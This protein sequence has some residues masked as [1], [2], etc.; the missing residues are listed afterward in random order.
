[1]QQD[2]DEI[3]EELRVLYVALTRAKEKLF[4]FSSFG[5]GNP[6]KTLNE[7][8]AKLDIENKKIH[9]YVVRSLSTTAQRLVACAILYGRNRNLTDIL[10]MSCTPFVGKAED[11]WKTEI[12]MSDDIYEE[13][14]DEEN[15]E[16]ISLNITFDEIMRRLSLE[17]NNNVLTQI[18]VKVSVSDIAHKG[19]SRIHSFS[20]RPAFLS[21]EDMTAAQKGTAIHALMQ[22]ADYKAFIENPHSEIERLVN[23]RFLSQP[24]AEIV[25]IQKVLNCFNNPFMQSFL[26]ADKTFRE[27]RF[28]VKIKASDIYDDAQLSDNDELILQ[29]AVDCA[30]VE[31]G[32]IIII[33]YK[34][35]RVKSMQE[36]KSRYAEQLRLY[37]YAMKLSTG[38][39]VSKCVIYSFTLNDTIEV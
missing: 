1:M 7:L 3:S 25:D 36:L 14:S 26:F 17:Y 10:E 16:S 28:A 4:M 33:D 37:S 27:Y 5:S 20:A 6:Q 13:F 30:Y 22:F 2:I 8:C 34:T 12:L 38:L 9:P 29:G 35:D 23:G 31:N 15:E 11:F 32:K 39:E 21:D 19:E 18:P 24:Q